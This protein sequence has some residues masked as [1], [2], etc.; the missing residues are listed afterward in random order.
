[1]WEATESLLY[2]PLVSLY[3]PLLF[4]WCFKM[5][6]ELSTATAVA[7]PSCWGASYPFV[8]QKPKV[9]PHTSLTHRIVYLLRVWLNMEV[10]WAVSKL[11][12]CGLEML[13]MGCSRFSG[14]EIGYGDLVLAVGGHHAC[15]VWLAILCSLESPKAFRF[16][17]HHSET[18]GEVVETCVNRTALDPVL[19][20]MRDVNGSSVLFGAPQTSG[21]AGEPPDPD[22]TSRQPG[23]TL[24]TKGQ[25][26]REEA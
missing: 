15:M 4:L 20:C 18:R 10:I 11:E 17:F 26:R 19:L 9:F 8:S 5:C 2:L 3:E 14:Q 12:F 21:R 1:M 24:E 25:S 23:T 6:S 16:F 13:K 7:S 22:P